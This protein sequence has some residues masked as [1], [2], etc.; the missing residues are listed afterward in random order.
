MPAGRTNRSKPPATA[1]QRLQDQLKWVDLVFE[2]RD[3]RVPATSKH[4][5]SDELFGNKPR[6][7]V[8]AKDDL[9]DPARIKDWLSVLSSPDKQAAVALALKFAQ[10]KEKLI[11]L[12]LELTKDKREQIAKKGLLP[13]PM[14]GCVVG[15]P[16]VGKSSLINWLIGRKKALVGNKPGVTKGTQWVRL[17]PQVELLDTPGI[18][19]IAQFDEITTNKLALLN[20]VPDNLYDQEEVADAGLT[21]VRETYPGMLERY[22]LNPADAAPLLEQIAQARGCIGPGGKFD[23]RRAAGIFLSDVRDGRVGRITLDIARKNGDSE[24]GNREAQGQGEA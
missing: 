20:L 24:K 15:M 9:A 23:I 21:L 22:G 5:K 3:A 17:H 16:N 4:P 19:P 14:R 8:L 2:V 18:L 7:I 12:V 11:S 6:I 1:F 10:G 13:R